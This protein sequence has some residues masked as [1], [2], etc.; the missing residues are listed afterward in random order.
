MATTKADRRANGR[1]AKRSKIA[2]SNISAAGGNSSTMD[3]SGGDNSA[4]MEPNVSM[5]VSVVSDGGDRS[6]EVNKKLD[7]SVENSQYVFFDE[8]I[9]LR[10]YSYA[11]CGS[12]K[13]GYHNECRNVCSRIREVMISKAVSMN[14]HFVVIITNYESLM[15]FFAFQQ[16]AEYDRCKEHGQ[17]QVKYQLIFAMFKKLT[18]FWYEGRNGEEWVNGG[19]TVDG[20]AG[21]LVDKGAGIAEA[22]E[23]S[24]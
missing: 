11:L 15:P 17:Q 16:C 18:S 24:R 13:F 19:P 21:A 20:T 10:G 5:I 3:S 6:N 2:T 9:M 22:I 23:T 14:L 8:N 4:Q 1:D 7:F 12:Q